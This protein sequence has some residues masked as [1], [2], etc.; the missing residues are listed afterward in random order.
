MQRIKKELGFIEV[1]DLYRQTISVA[2]GEK[3]IGIGILGAK[4]SHPLVYIYKDG[5]CVVAHA[6]KIPSVFL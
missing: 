5:R 1:L 4:V 3:I 6:T 2:L